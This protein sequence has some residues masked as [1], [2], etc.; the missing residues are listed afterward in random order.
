M[1]KS[2][3]GATGRE[4]A[5]QARARAALVEVEK[6]E[7]DASKNIRAIGRDP[8]EV[9]ETVKQLD[10][11]SLYSPGKRSER[12]QILLRHAVEYLFRIPLAEERDQDRVIARMGAR[13]KLMVDWMISLWENYL[14]PKTWMDALTPDQ[15]AEWAAAKRKYD[16]K[17]ELENAK[18]ARARAEYDRTVREVQFELA[19]AREELKEVLRDYGVR[20]APLLAQVPEER[21]YDRLQEEL[22]ILGINFRPP[23][24]SSN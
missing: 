2:I 5:A 1:Q 23:D 12:R 16:K 3:P 18:L 6:R 15:Q 13:T 20:E 24:D 7:P 19:T 11:A 4:T 21:G 22:A 17:I 8:E 9:P 10:V 14:R